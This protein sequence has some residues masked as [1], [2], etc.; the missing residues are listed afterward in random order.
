MKKLIL[1]V[2]VPAVVIVL[3]GAGVV[4]WCWKNRD[5]A[6]TRREARKAVAKELREMPAEGVLPYLKDL[7]DKKS[8]HVWFEKGED[9]QERPCRFWTLRAAS[10]TRVPYDFIGQQAENMIIRFA[11]NGNEAQTDVP[12]LKELIAYTETL[13]PLCTKEGA[14]SLTE[15]RLDGF[16]LVGDYDSAISLLESGKITSRT[17]AWCKGTAAKLR[18]HKAMD[19]KDNREAIRQLQAFI[20]FML[21]DEQKDFEDCDPTS[22]IFYSREWVVAR[23]YMRCFNMATEMKDAAKAAE[24]KELAKKNFS[25]ALKKAKDDQ[26]SLPVLKEEAKSV[27]L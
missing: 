14:A 2:V 11:G 21:S 18:A 6:E 4:N 3:F 27:G 19:A 1:L 10:Q 16:F 12:R 9:G 20:D 8:L 26:K 5:T 15:R 23:N 25:I 7:R 17:P 13:L 22:G 24:Y